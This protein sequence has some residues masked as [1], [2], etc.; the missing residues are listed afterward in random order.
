MQSS[1]KQK[2][3]TSAHR[4]FDLLRLE[5]DSLPV[6]KD[7]LA[8]VRLRPSPLA[9]LCRKLRHLALVDTLQENTGGL[10]RAG[11]DTLGNTQFNWVGEADLQRNELLS[12]VSRGNGC[13]LGLDGSPITDTDKTQNTNVAFGYTGDVVLEE[14]SDSTC[15]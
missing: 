13:R 11:L 14:C 4:L 3:D 6:D 9:N 7:T 12:G 1:E 2:K 15:N 10:G 5:L 8:L